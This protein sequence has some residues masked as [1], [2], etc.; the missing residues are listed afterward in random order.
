MYAQSYG[1]RQSRAGHSRT[2]RICSVYHFALPSARHQYDLEWLGYTVQTG[3]SLVRP[4][5][6]ALGAVLSRCGCC[7]EDRSSGRMRLR[8]GRSAELACSHASG[9]YAAQMG[10]CDL[11]RGGIPIFRA[12]RA[13][14][15]PTR[16]LKQISR[17]ERGPFRA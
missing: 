8:P 4:D 3:E 12:V 16:G 15:S 6:T 2:M 9:L 13:D 17:S 11:E 14:D 5:G 7:G 1:P 10:P